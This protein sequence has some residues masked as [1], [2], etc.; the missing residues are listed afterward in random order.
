MIPLCPVAVANVFT[1]SFIHT[2][3]NNHLS[4]QQLPDNLHVNQPN[5]QACN[6]RD[7]QARSQPCNQV[8]SQHNNLL[9]NHRDIQRCNQ[10]DFL[11]R[12]RQGNRLHIQ[13][14]V[15]LVNLQLRYFRQIPDNIILHIL[16]LTK[17]NLTLVF[18]P[19]CSQQI[20][21]P[22]DR[23]HDQLSHNK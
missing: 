23:Q 19:S 4:L 3:T 22:Q 5:S 17:P 18:S 14:H 20:N 16:D 1:L 2:T 8:T 9:V 11:L 15:H 7:N 21:Q 6:Q 13:P 10:V 12:N